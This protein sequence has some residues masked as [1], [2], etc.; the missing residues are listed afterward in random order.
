MEPKSDK[1]QKS[2]TAVMRHLEYPPNKSRDQ[3]LQEMLLFLGCAKREAL[4]DNVFGHLRPNNSLRGAESRT[5]AAKYFP[6]V[7]I[8]SIFHKFP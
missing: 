1:I 7:P 2:S 5:C 8:D 3:R 6:G 4:P